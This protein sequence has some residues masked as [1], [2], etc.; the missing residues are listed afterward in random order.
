MAS[1]FLV[2]RGDLDQV[3]DHHVRRAELQVVGVGELLDAGDLLARVVEQV[4]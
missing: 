3:G 1:R 4:A 2:L